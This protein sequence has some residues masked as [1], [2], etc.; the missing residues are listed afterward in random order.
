MPFYLSK[1]LAATRADGSMF[2]DNAQHRQ[3]QPVNRLSETNLFSLFYPPYTAISLLLL[4]APSLS[5]Q[6]SLHVSTTH[7]LQDNYDYRHFAREK[8]TAPS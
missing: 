2:S 7:Q 1:I 4:F 5:N 8:I 6:W 3:T